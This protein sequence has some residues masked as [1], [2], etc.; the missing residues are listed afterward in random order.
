MRYKI[1][2]EIFDQIDLDDNGTIAI[3]EFIVK[4]IETKNRLQ[5]RKDE[6][7]RNIVDHHRQQEEVKFKLQEAMQTERQFMTQMGIRS[8]SKLKVHI[9][10]AQNLEDAQHQVKV[11]QDNSYAET[12]LRVGAAPIWNE[13]IVF[14]IKDPYQPVVIQLVNERQELVLEQAL[15]L[16]D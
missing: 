3:E 9:V 12:N 4:Y 7:M 10:D 1:V 11:F 15:D 2:D 5:E 16:N 14:D 6:V 8:D 13:A